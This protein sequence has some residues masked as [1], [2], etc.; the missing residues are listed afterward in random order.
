MSHTTTV[1][2]IDTTTTPHG[3]VSIA[4]IKAVLQNS[5]NDIGGLIVNGAINKWAKYKPVSVNTP[6]IITDQQRR[7][8]NQGFT[9]AKI[10]ATS[11]SAAFKLA[12]DNGYD[13]EYLHNS[14]PFY[15]FLDFVPPSLSGNGYDHAA[16][17]PFALVGSDRQ[18]SPDSHS[19]F[20]VYFS[21][22][23]SQIK[24]SDLALYDTDSGAQYQERWIY[25]VLYKYNNESYTAARFCPLYSQLGSSGY[26]NVIEPNNSGGQQAITGYFFADVPSSAKSMAAVLCVAKIRATSGQSVTLRDFIFLPVLDACD[27]YLSNQLAN[28]AARWFFPPA[29]EVPLRAIQ[30]H[31]FNQQ[32]SSG[33]RQKITQIDFLFDI[34]V[35]DFSRL[36]W[37]IYN[38]QLN[39]GNVA[40]LVSKDTDDFT[41]ESGDVGRLYLLVEDVFSAASQVYVDNMTNLQYSF[42]LS[43]GGSN[44]WYELDGA[45]CSS[46]RP[47]LPKSTVT[48]TA[49]LGDIIN[50]VG[51]S[52]VRYI[53]E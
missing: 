5:R 7:G 29:S 40:I 10:H 52:N 49:T 12:T 33:I 50:A 15:R 28:T 24:L 37:T 48:E 30:I 32:A 13:W 25:G 23:T 46:D 1:I 21:Y 41:Q 34:A 39:R 27:I 3:G 16:D 35:E 20:G 6:S 14:F 2:Y 22:K 18:S 53:Q 19:W 38:F 11:A 43:S 44:I 9:T 42:M 4:D 26:S 17:K 51:Q 8:T 45:G 47:S 36:P 31:Y